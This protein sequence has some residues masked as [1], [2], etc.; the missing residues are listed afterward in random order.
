MYEAV[1]LSGV[2]GSVRGMR[3]ELRDDDEER[4]KS[5]TELQARCAR[6]MSMRY[7]PQREA[8]ALGLR[9]MAQP[10]LGETHICSAPDFVLHPS[11]LSL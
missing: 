1:G 9:G 3:V 11:R 5:K 6:S 2:D 8:C 7:R 10:A 4:C